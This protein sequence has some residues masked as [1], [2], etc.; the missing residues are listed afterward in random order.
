MAAQ[1]KGVKFGS[2]RGDP[3]KKQWRVDLGSPT[4]LRVHELNLTH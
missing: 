2:T 1:R 4:S 3:K